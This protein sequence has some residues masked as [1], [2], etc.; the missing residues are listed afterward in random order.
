MLAVSA[1]TAVAPVERMEKVLERLYFYIAELKKWEILLLG[2]RI[3][4][5]S[6]GLAK[7]TQQME[8]QNQF[9]ETD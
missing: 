3:K 8:I 1:L 7:K 2:G 6:Y 9:Q 4:R 5:G